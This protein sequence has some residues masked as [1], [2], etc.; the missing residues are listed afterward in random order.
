MSHD[1]TRYS[2]PDSFIPERF[3]NDDGSLKPN[4]M[5]HIAFGF[6]RRICVGRHF[7]DTSL[8]AAI[9][10]VLAVFKILKPLD[11]SGAEVPVEPRFSAG[12]SVRPL[13]F[14]CR[15]VPR[16]PGMDSEKLEELIVASTA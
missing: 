16:M 13:P 9:A 1:E 6:G 15:I 2:N 3:L 12:I 5:E 7:A 14:Q 11:E 8:W 4:D 10:K